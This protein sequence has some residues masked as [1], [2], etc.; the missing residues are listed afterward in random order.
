MVRRLAWLLAAAL[1]AAGPAG[2]QP[3]DRPAQERPP[4]PPFE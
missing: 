3:F 4:L 1:A 2:A